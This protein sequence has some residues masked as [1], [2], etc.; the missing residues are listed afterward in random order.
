MKILITG[1]CGFIGSNFIRSLLGRTKDIEIVNLDKLTYAGNPENLRDIEH[2]PRYQFIKGDICDRSK[3]SEAVEGCD[4]VINFAAE[5]H[6][7]RSIADA[8]AFVR[9][10]VIG[11]QVLLDSARKAGVSR[12]IQIGTDEVYG[13]I[14][15]GAFSEISPLNPSSPYSASKAAGDML[16]LSYFRTFG[17]PVIVTRSSNNYGPFQFPEKLIPLFIT[18]CLEGKS[19]PLYGDGTNVREWI[20]V[21][22][23]C[24]AIELV[25]ERGVPGEI[26]NISSGRELTNREIALTIVRKFEL[27][28][29][30]ITPVA[31][32]PGHDFRYAMDCTKIAGLGF[33][34]DTDV[35][36]GLEDTI[37]WYRDHSQWW[38]PLKDKN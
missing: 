35:K 31:D 38:K 5:S 11:V 27:P 9:T 7:D 18:N 21:L 29:R 36:T 24:R 4:A 30:F 37:A 28:E 26:Y 13:S 10:G 23:N 19:L 32:R 20:H 3:V 6:V 2:D 17:M 33:V 34:A 16:A 1:G 14:R 12:F 8:D 25:L 22:D 15:E